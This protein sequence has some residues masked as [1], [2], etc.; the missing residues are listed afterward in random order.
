MPGPVQQS[1]GVY[2]S[3]GEGELQCDV[4]ADGVNLT[5]KRGTLVRMALPVK[6][7]VRRGPGMNDN[8]SKDI[9]QHILRHK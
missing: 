6:V 4:P 7:V 1:S 5:F 2:A 3:S 8:Q 9:S